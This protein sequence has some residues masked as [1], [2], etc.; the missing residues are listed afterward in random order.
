VCETLDLLRR[1]Q[2]ALGWG[3]KGFFAIPYAYITD[4][5]LASDFWAITA[6]S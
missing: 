2:V 3:M 4:P 6:V 1:E 5:N